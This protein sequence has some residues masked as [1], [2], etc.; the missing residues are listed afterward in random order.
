M[1]RMDDVGAEK[2]LGIKRL[3]INIDIS[4]RKACEFP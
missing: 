3:S 2:T 4:L 1:I